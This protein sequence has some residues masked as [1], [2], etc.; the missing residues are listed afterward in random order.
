MGSFLNYMVKPEE[1]DKNITEFKEL[2]LKKQKDILVEL[3]NKNQLYVN[4]SEIE[5]SRFKIGKED[6]EV[7]KS[8]YRK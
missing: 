4:K 8:F 2:P 3:L 7:N 5:D 6:K 1:F